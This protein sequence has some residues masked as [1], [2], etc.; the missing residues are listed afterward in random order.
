[1]GTPLRLRFCTPLAVPCCHNQRRPG[2]DLSR[3]LYQKLGA[4]MNAPA[5]LDDIDA[6]LRFIPADDRDIW[7]KVGMA[8]RSELGDEGFDIWDYW[9]QSAA[10]YQERAAQLVWRSFT[11][12]GTRVATLFHLA[13]EHGYRPDSKPPARRIPEKKPPAP[14]QGSTGKYAAEIWL[15]ADCSDDAVGSPIRLAKRHSLGR[16]CW[17]RHR[18]WLRCRQ[19]Y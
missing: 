15:R 7:V 13:K 8:I 19:G 9:S 2:A 16:W 10:S 17:P 1:M 12:G 11:S 5:T 4:V 18:Y 3:V 14:Q 6:A